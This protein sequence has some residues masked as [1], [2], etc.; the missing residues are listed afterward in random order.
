MLMSEHEHV[1]ESQEVMARAAAA[2]SSGGLVVCD[3]T[4]S[5]HR[6]AL[7]SWLATRRTIR[8]FP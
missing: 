8:R 7:S 5:K 1:M 2:A 3:S 6:I 4:A